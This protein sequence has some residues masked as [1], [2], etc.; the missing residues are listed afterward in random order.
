[1]RPTNVTTK[2]NGTALFDCKATGIPE[3][4]ILWFTSKVDNHKF[5]KAVKLSNNSRIESLP[6]NSLL[7]LN[8]RKEDEGWYWCIAGNRGNIEQKNAYL[9]V[10]LDNLKTTPGKQDGKHLHFAC[11]FELY[12][13]QAHRRLRCILLMYSSHIEHF[14]L[15]DISR[16]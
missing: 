14:S 15:I 7:V 3:P 4:Q 6:N 1:M 9:K 16:Q 12:F 2:E 11:Y 10:R 8:V 13:V 5:K